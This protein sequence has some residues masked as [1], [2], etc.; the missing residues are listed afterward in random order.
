MIC[1]F[2]ASSFVIDTN[3]DVSSLLKFFFFL[4]FF[5]AALLR[6]SSS[7]PRIEASLFSMILDRLIIG[8]KGV[9]CSW[10]RLPKSS[11]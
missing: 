8:I 6:T 9:I 10:L 5:C 2:S 4:G 11:S 3:A 1:I 7:H